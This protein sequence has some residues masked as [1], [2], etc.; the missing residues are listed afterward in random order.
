MY[1]IRSYYAQDGIRGGDV[2][3]EV[4]HRVVQKVGLPRQRL[5][6]AAELQ[7]D[8]ARFGAIELFGF[9]RLQERDGL[10]DAGLEIGKARL[11]VLVG[12]RFD[13]GKPGA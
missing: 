1:A 2:E 12:R 13:T 3:E 8:L 5:V 11:V 9:E 4:R 7:F 6:H 10:F